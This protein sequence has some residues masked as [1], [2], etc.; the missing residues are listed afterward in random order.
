MKSTKATALAEKQT[1][2]AAAQDI[3]AGAPYVA[4]IT[5][6][7]V[8]PLLFHSWNTEAVKEKADA[9][10]GSKTKKEDNIESYVY[11]LDDRRLGIPGRNLVTAIVAAGRY[12]Q[13]PRSPRKSM[14]E[15]LRAALVPL[16][17][18]APFIP[19]H[20]D[21]DYL[22]RQREVVQRNAITRTRPAMREGWTVKFAVLVNLPQYVGADRLHELASQAGKLCG[23]CDKRPTYGRFAV[24]RFD[25]RKA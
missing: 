5:V 1:S 9:A 19:P 17:T 22:D 11:R 24:T 16:D 3:E 6:S 25:V 14:M 20:K 15:L 18:V 23:L 4:E 12:A 7:G 8:A 13:D 10:K 21:W 2:N